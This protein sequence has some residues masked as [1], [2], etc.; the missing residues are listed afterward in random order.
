MT[1]YSPSVGYDMLVV[2]DAPMDDIV[3]SLP[4]VVPLLALA[5]LL[6]FWFLSNYLR[7]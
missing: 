7:L 3:A 2:F 6:F 4:Y 1:N 5:V